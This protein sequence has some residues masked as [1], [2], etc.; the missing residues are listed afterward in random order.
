MMP[1]APMSVAF[2]MLDSNASGMRIIGAAP[3]GGHAAIILRDFV[4]RHRAVLHLEPDEVEMLADFA[5]QLG[6][7]A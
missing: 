4:P 3:T 6:I 2:W 5:V 7:E 1:S